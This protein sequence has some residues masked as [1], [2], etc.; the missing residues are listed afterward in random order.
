MNRQDYKS[1]FLMT[2]KVCKC[3]ISSV[4]Y[5]YYLL[6]YQVK[7]QDILLTVQL[8]MDQDRKMYLKIILFVL[9]YY[10]Y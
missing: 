6:L 9:I 2:A 8:A 5:V 7:R 4:I 1:T 10:E 3:F